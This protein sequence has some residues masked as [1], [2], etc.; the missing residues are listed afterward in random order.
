MIYVVS[1]DES[2]AVELLGVRRWFASR[3]VQHLSCTN[4]PKAYIAQ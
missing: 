1:M 4:H 2:V 3:W